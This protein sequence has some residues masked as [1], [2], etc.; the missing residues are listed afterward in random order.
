MSTQRNDNED[1]AAALMFELTHI[2]SE[3]IGFN[4]MMASQIAEALVRGLRKRM[5]GRDIYIPAPDKSARDASI[6][7]EFNGRNMDELCQKYNL[8]RSAIYKIVSGK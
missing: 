8:G 2:V 4:E 3:E 1:N 5:G 6:R 7:A